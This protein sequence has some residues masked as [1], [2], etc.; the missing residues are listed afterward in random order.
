MHRE[1][2]FEELVDGLYDGVYMVDLERRIT[3]WNRGAERITGYPRERAVGQTCAVNLLAHVDREGRPLC[4]HE[5]CPAVAVMRT[6]RPV[7]ERVFLRH[8]EGHRVPVRTRIAPL[9]DS[10]GAILGAVEVFTDDSAAVAAEE[11]L[12]RLRSASLLDP[13]TGTGNRHFVEA[14]LASRVHAFHRYGWPLGVGF[15]DVDR[16]KVVNDRF[17]HG[18]GDAVLRRVGQTLRRAVRSSDAVGRWGGDEFLVLLATPEGGEGLRLSCDRL[19]RLVASAQVAAGDGQ[20]APTVS[21][22]ATLLRADD[23]V[24]SLVARADR[25]MYASKAAGRDRVTCDR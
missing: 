21:I 25:M 2:F 24:E 20:V 1:K 22:G 12:E 11:E 6:G 16:F 3:Y 14:E 18:A 10:G 19:R 15:V 9:L 13:L 7:E 17:G 23:T 8:A 4:G 5:T